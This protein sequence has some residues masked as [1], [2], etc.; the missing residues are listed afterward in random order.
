MNPSIGPL[1]PTA[2]LR[3]PGQS[4]S[5]PPVTKDPHGAGKAE[6]QWTA[7]GGTWTQGDKGSFQWPPESVLAAEPLKAT[8]MGHSGPIQTP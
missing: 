3:A 8:P 7:H 4:G 2:G 6:R 1:A 5:V